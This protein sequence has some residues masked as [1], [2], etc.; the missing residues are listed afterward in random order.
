VGRDELFDVLSNERRRHALHYLKQHE[1]EKVDLSEL[2][3]QVTAWEEQ[4]SPDEICYDDRKSVHT[5]L[6]QFHVPKMCDAGVVDFQAQRNTVS[7]TDEG[8]DL[9]LYLETVE[10]SDIPWSAYFVLLSA[11]A[12]SVVVGVVA[13]V[14][15][16]GG[17]G[18][19]EAAVFVV[20]LFLCSSLAFA[21]DSRYRMRMGDEGPP[22]G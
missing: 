8:D 13:G 1:G 22:P 9:T 2:S 10:G 21:Y 14:P 18:A 20:A 19:T 7:L 3:T 4:V 6:T 17:F 12:G 15:G 11:F 5:A 16:L